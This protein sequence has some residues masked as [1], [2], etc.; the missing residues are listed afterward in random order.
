MENVSI[1]IFQVWKNDIKENGVR[2]CWL[3]TAEH[4]IEMHEKQNTQENPSQPPQVESVFFG[5]VF[6]AR[7][8]APS[9]STTLV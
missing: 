8:M 3:T 6:R 9:Q 5:F 4:S 7:G 2:E 1:K